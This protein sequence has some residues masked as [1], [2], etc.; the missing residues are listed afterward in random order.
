M[1]SGSL[2]HSASHASPLSA[3]GYNHYGSLLASGHLSGTLTLQNSQLQVLQVLNSHKAP[4]TSVSFCHPK[5]GSL[6][7]SSS[8]DRTVCVFRLEAD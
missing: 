3:L 2:L 4:V 1:T 6:L 8:S 5:W 7:A